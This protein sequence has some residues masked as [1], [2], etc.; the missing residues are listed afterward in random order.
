MKTKISQTLTLLALIC[1]NTPLI[2]ESLNEAMLRSGSVIAKHN[3]PAVL[4]EGEGYTFRWVTQSYVPIDAW[5]QLTLPNGTTEMLEATLDR[6]E[7]GSYSINDQNSKNYYFE[8]N[9]TIPD[10]TSG[11]TRIGFYHAQDD[12]ENP[13]RMY[14]LLPSG[15]VDRPH[16][17]AGKNFYT[18]V[19]SQNS[20]GG[21]CVAYV[22]N[23]FGGSYSTM[24]GLCVHNDCGAHHAYDDWDLGYGK[25]IIPK[26]NSIMVIDDGGGLPVGHVAVV[27]GVEDNKDGTWR[28]VTQE[29]NWDL[30]EKIDCGSIYTFNADTQKVTRGNK[31]YDVSGFIYSDT[32]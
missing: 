26:I 15:S 13:I 6:S 30:D 1:V 19:C 23:Y 16:G 20:H 4:N 32:I 12:G 7:K 29:S 18:N 8:V 21:Q 9:Y 3:I 17:T 14:G 28:L 24:P 31:S 2:A 10:D 22:R 25:G 27:V 5:L 11:K